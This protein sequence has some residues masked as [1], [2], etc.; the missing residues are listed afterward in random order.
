MGV[1]IIGNLKQ[2]KLFPIIGLYLCYLD[3]KDRDKYLISETFKINWLRKWFRWSDMC[4]MEKRWWTKKNGMAGFHVLRLMWVVTGL[5]AVWYSIET[6]NPGSGAIPGSD[7]SSAMWS[8]L[9]FL[10][11]KA[12]LIIMPTTLHLRTLKI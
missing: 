12:G 1:F 2:A 9:L 6:P 7:L 5:K 11:D 3:Y 10:V 8:K 4:L